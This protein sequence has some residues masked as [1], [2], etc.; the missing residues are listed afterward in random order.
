MKWSVEPQNENVNSKLKKMQIILNHKHYFIFQ[1]VNNW[2]IDFKKLVEIQNNN[3][4]LHTPKCFVSSK[5]IVGF[6]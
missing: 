4:S 6:C 5:L 2:I 1:H 3:K